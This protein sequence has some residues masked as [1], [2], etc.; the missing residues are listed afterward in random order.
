MRVNHVRKSNKIRPTDKGR[1]LTP[2][3][4]SLW[5][6][7]QRT[8][9][10][11]LRTMIDSKLGGTS[12]TCVLAGYETWSREW[13]RYEI[14]RSLMRGNGLFTVYINNCKCPNE[15]YSLR[16]YDP[17]AGVALGW[18][19][20]IY[21][22]RGGEWVLYD[23]I[24]DKVQS[25]PAWLPKPSHERVMPLSEGTKAYDWI[26]DDGFNNLIHWAN[27]AAIAAGK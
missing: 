24:T 5:E 12:V 14:A 22:H 1:Q 27:L 4:R 17:L 19:H 2:Q 15:G 3:D 26:A 20:R 18:D 25:W 9:P 10:R 7:I 16:G 8:N 23:K 6:K 11:A 21:E 13:V